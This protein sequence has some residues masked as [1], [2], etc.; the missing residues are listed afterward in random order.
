MDITEPLKFEQQFE[1]QFEL[2]RITTLSQ[3]IREGAKHVAEKV[4]SHNGCVL[5]MA[6]HTYTGKRLAENVAY[7]IGE[8]PNTYQQFIA[9]KSGV[10]ALV[11][12]DAEWKH[13]RGTPA[14]TIADELEAMGY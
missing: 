9:D 4:W 5:A 2:Q 10:P 12:R 13:M 14:L 8:G 11:V 3:A 6:C 7:Q 1:G